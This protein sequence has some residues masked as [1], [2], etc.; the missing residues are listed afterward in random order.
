[1]NEWVR[2][3][4]MLCPLVFLAGIVDAIAGGGGLITLPAYLA[5]GIP[6]HSAVA[7]NKCSSTF[8][9]LLSTFRFMRGK[10]IHYVAAGASAAAALVGS[11][12]GA[13]LNLYLDEKYLQYILLIAIP[14]IAVL[15]LRKKD[16]GT[17]DT[18][19]RLPRRK[20]VLSAVCTGF[21][22]GMY[23]GFLGPGTGS[24]LILIYTGLI[25][26]DLV[27]ASGN[28]KVVNAAANVA[29]FLTYAL[30][31]TILWQFGVPALFFGLAGNWIGSGLA[32]KKGQKIIRPLF[33][34]V[35]ILLVGKI[36]CDMFF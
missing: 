33:F 1:M 19:D 28:A 7:T 23:D 29:A 34:I 18:T 21:C 12:L 2:Q 15:V 9:T 5:L 36:A 3:L 35:L 13:M 27:T 14:V 20:L 31:G 10:R 11:P 26:F 24:F 22:V 17:E 8:G 32:L 30:H 4:C 16:F 25:G 6:P